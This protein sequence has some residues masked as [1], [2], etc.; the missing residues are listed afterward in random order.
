MKL[1]RI[2]AQLARIQRL[3]HDRVLEDVSK[4]R[5]E[6]AKEGYMIGY[7]TCCVE[8]RIEYLAELKAEPGKA[9]LLEEAIK[10]AAPIMEELT[11]FKND[12]AKRPDIGTGAYK[13]QMEQLV[14]AL[15]VYE[16]L[17]EEAKGLQG[18]T[19][20]PKEGT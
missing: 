11:E 1:K 9:G 19:Q 13:P 4:A 12:L 16:T 10:E 2:P 20:A 14:Q 18:G 7:A 6:G 15:M 5:E 3:I 17:V 8:S